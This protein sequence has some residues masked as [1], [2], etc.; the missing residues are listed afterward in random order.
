MPEI[1]ILNARCAVLGDRNAITRA[2]NTLRAWSI[3]QEEI[4]AIHKEAEQADVD[5]VKTSQEK[6]KEK[7][8]T[9]RA[10]EKETRDRAKRE[11]LDRWARV[12]LKAPFDATIVERNV[13]LHEVVVD[14]TT[15]LFVLAQV[16][17]IAVIAN[18]AGRRSASASGHSA[19]QPL[20]DHSYRRRPGGEGDQWTD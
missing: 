17:R 2:E 7:A 14:G 3:P 12:E 8:K 1:F 19:R 18:C 5:A 15:N 11:Q 16:D 9:A 4:D 13:A 10:R 20:L 6:D